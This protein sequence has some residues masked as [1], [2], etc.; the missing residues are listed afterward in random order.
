V[1]A[2][3]TSQFKIKHM[4]PF[5]HHWTGCCYHTTHNIYFLFHELRI[6]YYYE[7]KKNDILAII[8]VVCLVSS[9]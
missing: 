5:A 7:I 6:W 1:V 3:T 2:T 4:R 8:K 9:K